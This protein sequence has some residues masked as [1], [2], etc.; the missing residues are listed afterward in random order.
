MGRKFK[1]SWLISLIFILTLT[2]SVYFNFK[3]QQ[4][5]N[6]QQQNYSIILNRSFNIEIELILQNINYAIESLR[7]HQSEASIVHQLDSLSATLMSAETSFKILDLDFAKQGASAFLMY[8]VIRDY[9]TYVQSDLVEE[10]LDGKLDINKDSNEIIFAMEMLKNDIT[11]LHHKFNGT[12]LSQV[13]PSHLQEEWREAVREII[14]RNND[15][16]LYRRMMIKY[17]FDGD[18]GGQ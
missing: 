15:F 10:I 11:L 9:Y 12:E 17:G 3:W 13:E 7:E 2:V 18:V 6:N 16:D 1:A 5:K 14:M 8:N 4:Y